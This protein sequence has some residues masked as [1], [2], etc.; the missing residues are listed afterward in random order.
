V[1]LSIVLMVLLLTWGTAGFITNQMLR[2]GLHDGPKLA[3]YS[4]PAA[5]IASL[6]MTRAVVLMMA[7]YLPMNETTARRRHELLGSVGQAVFTINENFGMA[8]VRDEGG[9]LYQVPCRL[10][11]S[12][13]AADGRPVPKGARVRLVAYNARLGLFYV[14]PHDPVA[15]PADGK[16]T[17]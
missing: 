2:P 3:L 5:F 11:P 16:A 14:K 12:S 4:V 13:L 1:P 7:R 8:S 10:D 17:A 15:A 6:L 9:D